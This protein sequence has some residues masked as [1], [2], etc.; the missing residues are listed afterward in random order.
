M[1]KITITD[2]F[3]NDYVDSASYDNLRKIASLV[4]GQKNAARKIL[5]T[6][7]EKNIKEKIKHPC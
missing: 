6:V 3:T 1:N 2:F 5:Y 7:L 4:D